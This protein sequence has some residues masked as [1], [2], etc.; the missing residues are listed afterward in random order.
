MSPYLN[1][2]PAYISPV[3]TN[4]VIVILVECWEMSISGLKNVPV[5]YFE[6]MFKNWSLADNFKW[7]IVCI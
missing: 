4:M 6:V 1:F 5:L 7:L 3:S 2:D